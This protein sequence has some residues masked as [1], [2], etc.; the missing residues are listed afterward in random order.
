L[1]LFDVLLIM[2][3][4]PAAQVLHQSSAG[5]APRAAAKPSASSNA[6]CVVGARL[7][8]RVLFRLFASASVLKRGRISEMREAFEPHLLSARLWPP[9]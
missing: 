3:V 9:P 5:R 6:G 4:L 8:V 1:T 2:I 7:L